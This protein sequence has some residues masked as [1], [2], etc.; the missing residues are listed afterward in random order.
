[1]LIVIGVGAGVAYAA[2]LAVYFKVVSRV[3][4]DMILDLF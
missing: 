4:V 2:G 3:L 1:M